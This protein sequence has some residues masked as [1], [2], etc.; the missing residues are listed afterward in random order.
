M[1]VAS[2]NVDNPPH[3]CPSGLRLLLTNI[4]QGG[5]SYL[6]LVQGVPPLCL[7][8]KEYLTSVCGKVI[9]Y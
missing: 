9:G 6:V 4:M 7:I 3:S 2:F 8:P 5:V 1:K